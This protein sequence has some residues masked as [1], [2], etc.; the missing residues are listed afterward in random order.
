MKYYPN[1]FTPL[2]VKK[3]TFK[4]R[5]FAPP[6]TTSRLV[7][8]GAPTQEGIDQY[9]TRS[10]G[11]FGQVTVTESFVD[12]EF[13]ARHE[14]GLD[15]VSP[16]LTVHHLES[17]HILTDAI[18]SHGAVAS[19]QLN[20]AGNT[21]HPALLGGKN[22][23]GPSAMLRDDGVQVDEM[24]EEMIHRVADHFA[25]A[26]ASAQ[27]LDFNMVML[28]GGHGWLLSQFTSPLSNKR[29]DRWGGSLE[30]RARFPLL[31]L[32]KVRRKVGEDFLIEYRVSGDERTPGGMRL[33]E[34]IAFCKMIEDKVDLIHVTSGMYFNH[35]E[36]KSFSSMFHDHGCNLDLAI[37]IKKAVMVPVV[38]VGGYNDP[39]HIEQVLADGLVDAIA[40][41]RQ[42]F[43][44]PEF[45]NKA[46]MGRADEIAPCLRCSCFNPLPPDPEKRPS[47]PPFECTVNPRSGRELRLRWAPPPKS[48]KDV[49]VVGGGVAGLYGAITAAERGHKVTLV[50][51]TDRLGG[52]LWFTERDNHKKDLW[53]YRN[54]LVVRAERAGVDFEMN[55]EATAGYIAEKNPHAVI[56]AVGADPFVP[57]I[58][59]IENAH[60][61]LW[62]YSNRDEVGESV[63]MIGGG[64]S[65]SETA[66]YL[67][68]KGKKVHIV[69]MLG[70]LA[71]QGNDSHRRALLPL[72]GANENLSWDLKAKVMEVTPDGVHFATQDGVE[73]FKECDTVLYAVGLRA[74][75]GLV[76]SLRPSVR[77]FVPVGDCVRPRF[78]LNA[79]YEGMCAALDL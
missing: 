20:H 58:E 61:C 27:A 18:R 65:G 6:V 23:I 11:G 71:V 49:L 57:P 78:I 31:V 54:S 77:W 70:E 13:A 56:C 50:E 64:L 55:T 19:I 40:L 41:G 48:S 32:D 59:G 45:V 38:S 2:K 8:G 7:I 74:R 46:L 67:A 25:V 47:A 66:L 60:F 75:E 22:P 17:I 4:N 1:I 42:Q 33:D 3:T 43:A 76:E 51:K 72:M 29:T 44:D 37:P 52:T 24:D 36:S 68:E 21:N 69:E 10:R 62:A 15:I 53:R 39:E 5:I 35:V 28:H 9:E 12:F 79:T 26:C 34:T 16:N 63:V 73:H 30:N 14:H